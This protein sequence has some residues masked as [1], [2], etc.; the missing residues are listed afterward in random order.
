MVGAGHGTPSIDINLTSNV[1]HATVTAQL[2]DATEDISTMLSW[3]CCVL[4]VSG[5]A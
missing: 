3:A 1:V 5:L 2:I 4:Y